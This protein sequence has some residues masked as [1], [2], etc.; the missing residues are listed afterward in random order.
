L[1]A[2]TVFEF[3]GR[4]RSGEG[5]NPTTFSVGRSIPSAGPR[6]TMLGDYVYAIALQTT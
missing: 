3:L 5:A 1:T 6:T 4:K 2:E